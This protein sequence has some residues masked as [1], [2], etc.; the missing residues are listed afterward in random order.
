MCNTL[1][2]NLDRNPTTIQH[3]PL[4][5]A[6]TIKDL[7]C[8]CLKAKMH[9]SHPEIRDQHKKVFKENLFKKIGRFN[10]CRYWVN[11]RIYRCVQKTTSSAYK[12]KKTF[13][14]KLFKASKS[15]WKNQ[16]VQTKTANLKGYLGERRSS[17]KQKSNPSY[18]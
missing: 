13:H 15:Y 1:C 14:P 9:F 2:F 8:R 11:V 7:E 12:C 6:A 4:G 16:L 10:S 17:R 18:Y 5:S 3:I